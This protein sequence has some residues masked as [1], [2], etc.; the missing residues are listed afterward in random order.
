MKAKGFTLIELLVVMVIIA[1]LVGLL[2]P[3]LGRAREEARKTQCRSNLRQIGLATAIYTNDNKGWTPAVYG[4][5]SYSGVATGKPPWIYTV[6][7]QDSVM[8]YSPQLY[9]TSRLDTFYESA[10]GIDHSY[11]PYAPDDLSTVGQPG[12]N[13]IPSGLGLLFAGGY[14]TQQGASVLYCP[15]N[16]VDED[17]GFDGHTGVC[18][19]PAG[20]PADSKQK[21]NKALK[22]S[23]MADAD[24][25]FWTTNGKSFW[26]D[27]DQDALFCP[28]MLGGYINNLWP[29]GGRQ[30]TMM[31]DGGSAKA[32]A[33]NMWRASGEV[34]GRHTCILG[35]YQVRPAVGKP[36]TFVSFRLDQNGGKAMA[37]DAIWG[38][39]GR[40]RQSTT[41]EY[42]GRPWSWYA[43]GQGVWDSPGDYRPNMLFSNHDGSYNVLFT[44]GSVKTF[45]DAGRAFYKWHVQE[46]MQT[47]I[48]DYPVSSHPYPGNPIAMGKTV[49]LWEQYFDPLYAQD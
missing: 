12:G 31:N 21:M 28:I 27:G 19:D 25:V 46:R 36:R 13:G 23:M 35:N 33:S 22:R 10:C 20:S 37:S 3:A 34:R 4:W 18:T 45:S 40:I 1:L 8:R 41:Y 11:W 15:S 32:T 14:L 47:S 44:D 16:T 26:S 42:A 43:A 39:Y 38:F 6:L 29:G 30:V 7:D 48:S 9:L 17:G 5:E 24:D 49:A 2:L